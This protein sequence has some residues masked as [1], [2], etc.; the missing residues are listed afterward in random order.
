MNYYLH[1]LAFLLHIYLLIDSLKEQVL[2]KDGFSFHCY[3]FLTKLLFVLVFSLSHV[4]LAENKQGAVVPSVSHLIQLSPSENLQ[5]THLLFES[6]I[7]QYLQEAEQSRPV[8]AGS[9]RVFFISIFEEWQ[10]IIDENRYTSTEQIFKVL[11]QT[12][13]VLAAWKTRWQSLYLPA[14]SVPAADE[15]RLGYYRSLVLLKFLKSENLP[16]E[17]RWLSIFQTAAMYLTGQSQDLQIFESMIRSWLKSDIPQLKALA[18]KYDRDISLHR[19]RQVGNDLLQA[20]PP[21]IG[22]GR[23]WLGGTSLGQ[24]LVSLL[25]QKAGLSSLSSGW[26]SLSIQSLFQQALIKM[27]PFSPRYSNFQK[28]LLAATS[29]NLVALKLF[30]DW[31]EKQNS[32]KLTS[33]ESAHPFTESFRRSLES[34]FYVLIQKYPRMLDQSG[35]NVM[36]TLKHE[37]QTFFLKQ[38]QKMQSWTHSDQTMSR[39]L[40]AFLADSSKTEDIISLMLI[41]DKRKGFDDRSPSDLLAIS[42]ALGRFEQLDF[43]ATQFMNQLKIYSEDPYKASQLRMDELRK[44]LYQN[45]P[46]G[47][48]VRKN[49]NLFDLLIGFG[50]NCV[51][52]TVFITSLILRH[53]E[54]IPKGDRLVVLQYRD[55]LL[56][57]L[58][59]NDG[60]VWDL[61]S[62]EIFPKLPTAAFDPRMLWNKI[63][64][65]ISPEKAL[66]NSVWKVASPDLKST[67]SKSRSEST[68]V[69]SIWKKWTDGRRGSLDQENDQGS[70]PAFSQTEPPDQASVS[71][72]SMGE[73]KPEEKQNSKEEKALNS[74]SSKVQIV[75]RPDLAFPESQYFILRP[76]DTASAQKKSTNVNQ[77]DKQLYFITEKDLFDYMSTHPEVS[78]SLEASGYQ[79]AL[80]Q[81]VQNGT[82]DMIIPKHPVLQLYYLLKFLREEQSQRNMEKL[83]RRDISWLGNTLWQT[84]SLSF[85]PSR[86]Y[87]FTTENAFEDSI[88]RF[89]FVVKVGLYCKNYQGKKLMS[90]DPSQYIPLLT[91]YTG[92]HDCIFDKDVWSLVNLLEIK[93]RMRR[94]DM[95]LKKVADSW[96]GN[97]LEVLRLI[98]YLDNQA[99]E[100]KGQALFWLKSK[101]SLRGLIEIMIFKASFHG[102]VNNFQFKQ[103]LNREIENINIRGT[104][105]E[106][107]NSDFTDHQKFPLEGISLPKVSKST[108]QNVPLSFSVKSKSQN[109]NSSPFRILIDPKVS[110]SKIYETKDIIAMS[111]FFGS[112]YYFISEKQWD[113]IFVHMQ[114]P[115]AEKR[116][117]WF[118]NQWGEPFEKFKTVMDHEL[119]RYIGI[120][121][122]ELERYI[123]I[124]EGAVNKNI[125]LNNKQNKFPTF[126]VEILKAA[127]KYEKI[128]SLIP[129]S[130]SFIP[131][132]D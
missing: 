78:D 120:M 34:Q 88:L 7:A 95:D 56:P 81:Y 67:D 30:N 38:D 50:G 8:Y 13:P 47:Y 23:L 102:E 40:L 60:R 87:K 121:D 53:P 74:Q 86:R 43:Q 48:Y 49:A 45:G 57:A 131:H 129:Q 98:D 93:E 59:S 41:Q 118:Q 55:H 101:E 119:E 103:L 51:A 54:W 90:F 1:E 84:R 100:K 82:Y 72:Y 10:K 127:K 106:E 61:D 63:L 128:K 114:D 77:I 44:F 18:E 92:Q 5:W 26:N 39:S 6:V 46:L 12:R 65:E 15:I 79:R 83:V 122:H 58:L 35:L 25:K 112:G 94:F 130:K 9:E 2:N 113:E 97:T 76:V 22:A 28:A 89:D 99:K 29:G 36:K 123:G 111:K 107:K 62:G 4:S 19:F 66:K 31:F 37:D 132:D 96:V 17:A 85:F 27:N 116:E 32:G 75:Y 16:A 124:K 11:F 42:M 21:V 70:Y 125:V 73:A 24:K 91:D 110:H 71:F 117:L 115:H 14:G 109:T 64:F 80:P 20:G 69:E 3:R 68:W 105:K 104:S 52:R 33:K 126:E 108:G